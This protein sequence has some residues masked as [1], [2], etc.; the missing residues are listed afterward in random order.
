[1]S[2]TFLSY[3]RRERARLNHALFEQRSSDR[4]DKKEIALL[5]QQLLVVDDQ[6]GRWT[7][8]LSEEGIAA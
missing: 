3:L 6:L 4:P 1:M 7:R 2:E 8:D 5:R